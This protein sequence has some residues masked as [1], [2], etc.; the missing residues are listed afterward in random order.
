MATVVDVNIGLN[1]PATINIEIVEFIIVV[2][3]VTMMVEV[4]IG[5]KRTSTI[6]L[7]IME[8]MLMLP[9]DVDIGLRQATLPPITHVTKVYLGVIILFSSC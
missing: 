7:A 1:R 6:P 4:D 5:F 3:K 8:K 2:I 9:G